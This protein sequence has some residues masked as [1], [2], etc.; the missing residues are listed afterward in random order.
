MRMKRNTLQPAIIN[1]LK[2]M[3]GALRTTEIAA[4]AGDWGT[5][6]KSVSNSLN[7][8][9]KK[10]V[11]SSQ[12]W[13][14]KKERGREMVWA[15]RDPNNEALDKRILNLIE[16]HDGLKVCQLRELLQKSSEV[17]LPRL[18]NLKKR[19]VIEAEG[20]PCKWYMAGETPTELAAVVNA[21][22]EPRPEPE[23][24]EPVPEPE[25][26]PVP[27]QTTKGKGSKMDIRK[28]MGVNLKRIRLARGLSQVTLAAKAG[29]SRPTVKAVE[30]AEGDPR[31]STLER[32]G[33]FLGY[34]ETSRFLVDLFDEDEAREWL[35]SVLR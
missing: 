5:T 17:L 35:L 25:P 21:L 22:P 30:K 8:L 9:R 32:L 4:F 20:Q 18:N 14:G 33:L 7:A 23:Y 16:D 13:A 6:K 27:K 34:E 2:E 10:G 28:V 15:L 29:L 26:Q 1:L 12:V 19:S 11:V 31:F 3:G 24:E